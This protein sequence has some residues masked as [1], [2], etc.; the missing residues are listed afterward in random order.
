MQRF[1]MEARKYLGVITP[2]KTTSLKE[3]T[4]QKPERPFIALGEITQPS[5]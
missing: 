5:P 4:L 1:N 2:I 3:A